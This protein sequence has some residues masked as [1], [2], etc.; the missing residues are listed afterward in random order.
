VSLRLAV[1]G[2]LLLF[3]IAAGITYYVGWWGSY[4]HRLTAAVRHW[5]CRAVVTE[6]G[7]E[8]GAARFTASCEDLGPMATWLRY[9]SAADMHAAWATMPA[10]DLADSTVCV[11]ES[12]AELVVLYDVGRR[13]IEDLCRARDG[14]VVG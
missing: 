5:D 12:R 14:R 11:S 1:A 13:R 4:E 6:H 10:D 2:L 3:A 8:R 7:R 9:R